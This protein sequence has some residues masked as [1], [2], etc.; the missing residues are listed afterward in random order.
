MI[1]CTTAVVAAGTWSSFINSSHACRSH[2]RTR[3][4]SDGLSGVKTTIDASRDL[5]S[6]R[7]HRASSGRPAAGRI[8]QRKGWFCETCH[9]GRNQLDSSA[10]AARFR[11]QFQPCRSLIP[12]RACGRASPDGLPVLGPCGEIDGLFYATGH[13]R[14]GIL[15]APLTGELISEAI[16]E[17]VAS[18][19]L[20]PF[21]PDRVCNTGQVTV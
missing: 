3:A 5:Q 1:N 12:G 4:R 7:L 9:G 6:S 19:L 14:N 10:C 2:D 20:A 21:S 18:P 8:D 13:Y 16:V 11:R 15:L 17:G